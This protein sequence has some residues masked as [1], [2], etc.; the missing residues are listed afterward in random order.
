MENSF[1]V[2]EE[3]HTGDI[4][5]DGETSAPWESTW[6]VLR[7]LDQLAEITALDKFGHNIEI[8]FAGADTNKRYNA[9]M[10][11]SAKQENF[12]FNILE[13]FGIVDLVD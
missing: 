13:V 12:S 9:R 4:L 8:L 11:E 1:G 3:H 7:S 5:S 6:H 10:T 2:Q